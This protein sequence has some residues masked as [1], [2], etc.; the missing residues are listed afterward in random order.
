MWVTERIHRGADAVATAVDTDAIVAMVAVVG[1]LM[2]AVVG[3]LGITTDRASSS[4]APQAASSPEAFPQPLTAP[5][6]SPDL[7]PDLSVARLYV[8]KVEPDT[9][10]FVVGF[11]AAFQVPTRDYR[12]SVLVGDPNAH[13][14]RASFVAGQPT[15]R[16]EQGDGTTWA[17]P[18]PTVATPT[19]SGTVEI[20][21]PV[22]GL[23]PG[24]AVW[25]EAEAGTGDAHKL[26]TSPYFSYDSLVGKVADGK[27][28]SST[29]GWVNSTQFGRV[30]GTVPTPD[31]GV[32]LSLVNQGLSLTYLDPAP[33][34]LMGSQISGIFDYIQIA[35]GVSRTGRNSDFILVDRVT[36]A[37]KLFDGS[38]TPAADVSSKSNWLV[39]GLP[40]GNPGAP[41]TLSFDM[42]AV[43]E[44]LGIS[45]SADGVA[46]G[47][48]RVFALPDGRSLTSAGV[49]GTIGWFNQAAATA[50]AS[51]A[52]TTSMSVATDPADASSSSGRTSLIAGVAAGVGVLMVIV[53]ALGSRRRRV[54]REAEVASEFAWDQPT[55]RAESA[56]EHEPEAE[57][58]L[59]FE[60]EAEV[61]PE[62][63]PELEIEVAPEARPAITDEE[64]A[65]PELAEPELAEPELAEPEL[66]EGRSRQGRSPDDVLAALDAELSDIS[67]RLDRLGGDEN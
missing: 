27:L 48:D 61:E 19:A 47:V 2:V 38:V 32:V 57:P 15:G 40:E 43:A 24:S 52:P 9:V 4:P 36:G 67:Q 10:T 33:A 14:V 55:S 7:P 65:E 59:E 45:L 35:P 66:A 6:S 53:L 8:S 16:V 13:Q 41:A 23:P 28:G 42:S 17:A 34:K 11:A 18:A 63:E 46:L 51:V 64:A 21:V 22:A 12:V 39:Q 54:R 56:T 60:V 31:R 25:T 58:V 37:V 49:L 5:I 44:A 20:A 26:T 3:V 30:A 62:A 1:V 29:W 50:P